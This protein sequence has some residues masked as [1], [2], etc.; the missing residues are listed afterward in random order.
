MQEF[1]HMLKWLGVDDY[2]VVN[3]FY[4]YWSSLIENIDV[5]LYFILKGGYVLEVF[6]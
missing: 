6:C 5:W 4:F 3:Y 1:V 2:F